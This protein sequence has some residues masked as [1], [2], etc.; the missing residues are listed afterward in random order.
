MDYKRADEIVKRKTIHVDLSI[1]DDAPITRSE[2]INFI[3]AVIIDGENKF[4]GYNI[5][6][7]INKF[8]LI[9][10]A[11]RKTVI[12]YFQTLERAGYT[13]I[14][15]NLKVRPMERESN[16]QAKKSPETILNKK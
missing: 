11:T 10:G 7:L 14:D 15:S 4:G 5:Q 6:R 9:Y 12:D 13:Y 2:R 8:V 3:Y 1:I 16:D